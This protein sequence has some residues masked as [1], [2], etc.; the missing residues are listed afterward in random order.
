MIQILPY[1]L[2]VG[3]EL[4][5]L[6]LELAYIAPR[7]GGVLISGRSENIGTKKKLR[8]SQFSKGFA[9]MQISMCC[10]SGDRD[11]ESLRHWRDCC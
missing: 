8:N 5:K 10:W 6:S 3:Q 4:L 2:I 1:S 9:N 11:Q 7:I